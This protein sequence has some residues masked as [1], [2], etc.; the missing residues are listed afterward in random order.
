MNK[1][2]FA[3]IGALILCFNLVGAG[4]SGMLG[5]ETTNAASVDLVLPK[6]VKD[7]LAKLSTI[8]EIVCDSYPQILCDKF[9][10]KTGEC[11]TWLKPKDCDDFDSKLGVCYKWNYVLPCNEVKKYVGVDLN[12]TVIKKIRD[13]NT[14]TCWSIHNEPL[15]NIAEQC[16]DKGKDVTEYYKER[17]IQIASE[18]SSEEKRGFEP[19]EITVVIK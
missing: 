8:T 3:I 9:D 12:K 10:D 2:W 17:L 11:T 18:Q 14:Q 5:G 13:T 6:E 7:K 4:V 16:L 19:E 15:I 1:I